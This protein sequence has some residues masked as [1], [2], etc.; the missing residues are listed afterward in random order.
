MVCD[1]CER[2]E[3]KINSWQYFLD[4]KKFFEEK[5]KE[6]VFKEIPV[7]KPYYIGTSVSGK[8]IE[9]YADKWYVCHMCNVTWEFIYPNFPA[10]GEVRKLY[11]SS[12]DDK[13]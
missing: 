4:V 2:E 10:L 9:W 6:G 13:K 5:E 7:K 3:I 12:Y 1:C 11:L 8:K